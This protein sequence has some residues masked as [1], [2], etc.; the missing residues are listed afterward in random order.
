MKNKDHHWMQRA[1]ELAHRAREV[2]EVP[3]GAVLVLNNEIIGEGWNQPISTNDPT[4]HAEVIA[5]R[6]GASHLRNYR[7]VGTTL[8]VTLEPCLMCTGAMV[9]ARVKRLV[10]GAYD[11]KQK[12]G[13]LLGL[14]DGNY[15]NHS[16]EWQG[17]V[18]EEQCALVLKAFFQKR[19]SEMATHYIL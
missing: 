11:S 10:F 12:G 13:N 1:L 3:V 14:L 9:H 18:R 19:R 7:L 5:L 8:Y 2:N 16:V 4:G 15:L 6:Q 17:G